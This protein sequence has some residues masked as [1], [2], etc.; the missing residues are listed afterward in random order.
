MLKGQKKNILRG[1][2]GMALIGQ[3]SGDTET[4]AYTITNGGID[5]GI[6]SSRNPG[7][8]EI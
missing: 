6:I 4:G 8:K 7:L 3:G 1:M 2:I 5:S